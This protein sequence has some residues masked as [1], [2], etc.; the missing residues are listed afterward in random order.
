MLLSDP[1]ERSYSCSVSERTTEPPGRARR[2]QRGRRRG[3]GRGRGRLWIVHVHVGIAEAFPGHCHVRRVEHG[4]SLPQHGSPLENGSCLE[5]PDER[6][7]RARERRSHEVAGPNNG[8]SC[9]A[10]PARSPTPASLRRGSCGSYSRPRPLTLL[11]RAV[12]GPQRGHRA[13]H[14][15]E[16]PPVRRRHLRTLATRGRGK[17]LRGCVIC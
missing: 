2:S 7:H 6:D 16:A 8:W 17:G 3:R 9:G 1:R 13:R 11:H 12:R 14:R 5:V 15:Q 10:P 4:S